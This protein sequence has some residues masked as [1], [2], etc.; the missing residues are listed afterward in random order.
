MD[1]LKKSSRSHQIDIWIVYP[2]V[3]IPMA[4]LVWHGLW[5]LA[6]VFCAAFFISYKVVRWDLRKHGFPKAPD[7]V[8]IFPFLLISV[9]M[10]SEQVMEFWKG[11]WFVALA[12]FLASLIL[13]LLP[14]LLKNLRPVSLAEWAKTVNENFSRCPGCGE[15]Y[16]EVHDCSWARTHP[17]C[18]SDGSALPQIPYGSFER[19]DCP[20]CHVHP[21]KYHHTDCDY[22]VCPGCDQCIT[23]CRCQ[24]AP[25][26]G[27]TGFGVRGLNVR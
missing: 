3:F 12:L 6:L 16:E 9:I 19:D 17:V 5:L 14:P 13:F 21:G 20:G 7:Q 18:F 25:E 27:C 11:Y 2:I 22:A 10:L 4:D 26:S 15:K 24:L 1:L 8:R 23:N